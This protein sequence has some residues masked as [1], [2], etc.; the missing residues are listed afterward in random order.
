[1]GN[2][3]GQTAKQ[4]EKGKDLSQVV[5][6]IASHYILT[7][8]FKDME[9]L[10]DEKYCDELILVTSDVLNKYLTKMDVQ[11]LAT[12]IK[13]GVEVNEMASDNLLYLRK[14]DLNKIDVKNPVAKKRMCIG[15]AKYY[16]KVAHIFA[17]IVTTIN[18]TYTYKDE[19]GTSHTVNFSERN[20]I[21]KGTDV[22]INKVNLCNERVN[23]LVNGRDLSMK[24][25]T[26]PIKI[27]PNFCQMNLN[28]KETERTQQK[29]LE[30]LINEPGISQLERLYN[31]VYDYESG[32]FTGMSDAMREEYKKDLAIL[33]KTFTGKQDMP[34]SIQ[35]FSQVPLR[36][37]STLQGCQGAPNNQYLLEYEGT[38]KQKLF[39]DYANHVKKMMQDANTNK[40]ALIAIL[41]QLFVFAVNPQTKKP[42]ITI[43]PKITDDLLNKLVRET[44]KLIIKLYVACE[45][46]FIKGLEIFEKIIQEQIKI[47]M[48][49]KID[50]LKEGMKNPALFVPSEK[51]SMSTSTSTSE[52]ENDV[53]NA[54]NKLEGM[55]KF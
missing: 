37:F 22:R 24:D 40:D 48:Q 25:S 36:D 44:Q 46:D 51:G 6:F 26:Q 38:T 3:Q 34:E 29:V 43:N 16:V 2:T 55:M 10:K 52:A 11:Y 21:P 47:T 42:E 4:A 7:Q 31:D 14:G 35:K 1:M 32:R 12:K 45:T 28:K 15:I 8:S 39:V 49:K 50:A 17:A 18:P 33:Y 23:A 9:S 27:K 41:D 53:D 54:K 13:K 30:T 20:K 5:N 19:F